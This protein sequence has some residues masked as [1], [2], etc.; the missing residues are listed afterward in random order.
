LL[1]DIG[2]MIEAE[3]A[4]KKDDTINIRVKARDKVLLQ[5]YASAG[6][7]RS[8]SEYLIAKGLQVA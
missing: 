1:Q 7:Y 4:K 2:A 6:G 3:Q 5:Q 8:L